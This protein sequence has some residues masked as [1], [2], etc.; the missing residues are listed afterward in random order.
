MNFINQ[1][2]FLQIKYWIYGV[3]I[4]LIIRALFNLSES[5]L[6]DEDFFVDHV[7]VDHVV[8]ILA[9][10]EFIAGGNPYGVGFPIYPFTYSPIVLIFF[11]FFN[12]FLNPLLLFIHLLLVYLQEIQI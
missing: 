9:V 10:K 12:E 8:Y 6:I 7:F 5:I 4:L 1:T 3:S 11:S 2:K